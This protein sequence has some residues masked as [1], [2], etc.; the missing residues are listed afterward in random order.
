M[1]N[2]DKEAPLPAP[3]TDKAPL[4]CSFC[5]KSQHQV[6]KLIAGPGFIFICDECV[7]LCDSIVAGKPVKTDEA[8]YKLGNIPSETLLARLKPVEHTI[9]GMAKSLE[10]MVE[11][12]RGREVSWARI[13]E[14]L[15]VSRQS[16]WERF[17]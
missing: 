4:H 8:K 16:A 13:G 15:G 9:Q 6:K 1:A 7:A 3:Y 14:A 11:E 17:S 5:L 2:P 12:L 10:S